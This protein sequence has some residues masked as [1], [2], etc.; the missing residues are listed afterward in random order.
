MLAVFNWS[1]PKM[2]IEFTN[3]CTE[4]KELYKSIKALLSAEDEIKPVKH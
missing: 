4:M 2:A 3:L 1:K